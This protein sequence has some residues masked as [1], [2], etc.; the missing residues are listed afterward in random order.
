MPRRERVLLAWSGGKDSALALHALAASAEFEV[1]GLL[2]TVTVDAA[3]IERIGVHGVRRELLDAQAAAAGLPL[4]PVPLP[5]GA[6]NAVYEERFAAALAEPR[7]GGL[8]RIAFGDLFL[9]DIRDYR[10]RQLAALGLSPL[11]PLWGRDTAAL[12]REFVA[13]GFA[14]RLV[15]IDTEALPADF[16]GRAFDRE[17]LEALPP[18]VDPC[19]ENGEFHTFV[20]AGPVLTRPVACRL[21]ELDVRGR[22]A[23]RDL[24]PG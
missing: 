11:F 20:T 5:A 10:Q 14:A 21:G 15:C 9:Q 2:T 16:A 12:A 22:F 19:G 17:L 3:G 23:Y 13:R 18:G 24:L 8:R 1:A 4:V 7:H 6:S